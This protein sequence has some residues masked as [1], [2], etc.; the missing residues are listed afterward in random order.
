[1][2]LLCELN[3]LDSNCWDKHKITTHREAGPF[4]N[5]L[6]KMFWEKQTLKEQY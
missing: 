1:M 2:K 4:M 5:E 6:F 3:D